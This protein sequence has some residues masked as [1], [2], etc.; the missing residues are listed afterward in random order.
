MTSRFHIS[1]FKTEIDKNGV[2][3]NNRFVSLIAIPNGL[4]DK[5]KEIAKIAGYYPD[6]KDYI[7]L[8]CETV[9][10]PGQ[11]FFTQ[12]LKRYGYG[13]IEKKPYLP[14]FNPMKMV[15]LVDRRGQIIKFFNDWA[16]LMVDH[17]VEYTEREKTYLVGYKDK[18]ISPV[19][20]TFVYDEYNDTPVF[21]A[22]TFECFPLTVSEY[23]VT[24]AAQ[25]DFIRLSVSM[26]FVHATKDFNDKTPIASEVSNL[27]PLSASL[28][29]EQINAQQRAAAQATQ[30]SPQAPRT[31]FSGGIPVPPP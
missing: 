6:N 30:Q 9:T 7:T 19:I 2:L 5:Y 25:N 18:Y 16:N 14:T 17:D 28:S 21:V 23:D 3:H 31:L 27:P 20:R 13:Q 22:K 8:R 26:Q 15:F 12:D 10:I 1:N 24:W 11:N 29:G 4:S